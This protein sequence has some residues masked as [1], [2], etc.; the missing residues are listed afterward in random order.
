MT[1]FSVWGG[2]IF[3]L[4]MSLASSYI[5]LWGYIHVKWRR[6]MDQLPNRDC[7]EADQRWEIPQTG[8]GGL[9]TPE[10]TSWKWSQMSSKDGAR[11]YIPQSLEGCMTYIRGHKWTSCFWAYT[12]IYLHTA[13]CSLICG[14]F[15]RSLL[16]KRP[17]GFHNKRR[18]HAVLSERV[19]GEHRNVERSKAASSSDRKGKLLKDRFKS[20]DTSWC[21]TVTVLGG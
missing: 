18:R 7:S 16:R 12:I 14:Q 13:S 21:T 8:H 19:R 10:D 17:S 9:M 20:K 5:F 2:C 6:N 15:S 3:S 4:R 11:L 1:C